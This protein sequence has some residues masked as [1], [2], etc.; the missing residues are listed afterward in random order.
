VAGYQAAYVADEIIKDSS[1][2]IHSPDDTVSTLDFDHILEHVK[3]GGSGELVC[4]V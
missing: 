4:V 3:V 2:Y 1:P